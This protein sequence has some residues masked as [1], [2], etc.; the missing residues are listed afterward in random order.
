MKTNIIGCL[1]LLL[2]FFATR[3]QAQTR[4]VTTGGSWD[5]TGIWTGGDIGDLITETVSFNN[6]IG[7]G[8][9]VTI[10]SPRNYTVGTVNMNAGND[11]VIAQGA[12]LNIGNSTNSRNLNPGN[13]NKLTVSGT[14]IIWGNLSPGG[15]FS[16][17]VTSTGTLVVKGNMPLGNDTD[18]TSSG[19]VDIDGA[20][21]MNGNADLTISGPFDVGGNFTMG[22]DAD[23][24]FNSPADINVGGNFSTGGNPDI[25]I[26]S[27]S[28]LDLGG[29]FTVGNDADVDVLGG[30]TIGGDFNGGG[31]LGL[32][33][34]PNGDLNIGDDI[35]FG[36][37]A[38][39]IVNGDMDVVGDFT[40]GGNPDIVVGSAGDLNVGEDVVM[41]NDGNINVDGSFDI[42][43][44]FTG[45]SNTDFD[46]DGV[47][48][49]GDDLSVGNDS[50]A[51]GSGSILVGDGCTDGNSTFCGQG[52][53]GVLPIRLAYFTASANQQQQ[54]E[55]NWATSLE[56]NFEKFVIQRSQNGTQFEDIGE[57]NALGKNILDVETK[58]TFVD[59]EPVIGFNYYRLKAIDLDGQ[60]EIFD[61]VVIRI[62]GEKKLSV[63]PN[64]SNGESLSW[65]LNFP[66][67]ENGIMLLLNSLG[68][69]LARMKVIHTDG[70]FEL[71]NNVSPGIYF[72]KY[73]SSDFV[74]T[75]KVIVKR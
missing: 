18:F 47:V 75:F 27:G 70:K 17:T 14:L 37:D 49:I 7:G 53:L 68:Q 33:V 43:G 24:I 8:G 11:L 66:P 74:Q 57:K 4:T 40:A 42:G 63:Y 20:F 34:G 13:D 39:I 60:F 73:A 22:N 41:N 5:N 30:L 48:T 9:I 62:E 69:E 6:D 55:L 72:I 23:I 50:N 35:T 15:N 21:S 29:N 51:V 59:T 10:P 16:I 28:S 26:A 38:D 3:S 45:G 1:V 64:P 58:Y 61:V 25:S 46:V 44:D 19:S 54:V 12:T 71:E 31:N 67:S 52:P 32:T 56:E 2:S 65:S 36:N